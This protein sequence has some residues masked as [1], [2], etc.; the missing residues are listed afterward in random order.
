MRLAPYVSHHSAPSPKHQAGHATSMFWQQPYLAVQPLQST[1]RRGAT[2]AASTVTSRHVCDPDPV[3]VTAHVV[4]PPA[5]KAPAG[6]A[7]SSGHLI[8]A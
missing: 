2:A 8:V 4:L 7:S 3:H 1:S 5:P 6:A